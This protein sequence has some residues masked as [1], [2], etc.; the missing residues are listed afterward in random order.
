[1]FFV[2]L[3]YNSFFIGLWTFRFLSAI[4]RMHVEKLRKLKIFRC[5]RYIDISDYEKEVEEIIV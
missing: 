5:L 4:F 2:I 1:M 3:G